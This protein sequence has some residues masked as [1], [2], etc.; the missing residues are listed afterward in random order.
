VTVDVQ[1]EFGPSAWHTRKAGKNDFGSFE[2]SWLENRKARIIAATRPIFKPKTAKTMEST[3]SP[4]FRTE[5][6]LH[7]PQTAR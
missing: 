7:Q 3:F 2:P 1:C 4:D 5:I 6:P